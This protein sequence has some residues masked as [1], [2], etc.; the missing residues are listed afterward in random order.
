M[1]RLLS[2][3]KWVSAFNDTHIAQ[4]L[5]YLNITG[6]EVG[7]APQLQGINLGLGSESYAAVKRRTTDCMDDT[8]EEWRRSACVFPIREIR[9]IRG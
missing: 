9:A 1:E 8:D 3:Q 4:M 7:G 6:L 2:I 5:G